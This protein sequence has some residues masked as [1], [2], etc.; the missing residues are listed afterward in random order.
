MRNLG[1]KEGTLGHMGQ[2]FG[3]TGE[4]EL[5][6]A[7]EDG[8]GLFLLLRKVIRQYLWS[9]GS[10]ASESSFLTAPCEVAL[11]RSPVL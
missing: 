5:K 4:R 1:L 11:D 2:D 8:P 10:P 9:S 7:D 3:F 6:P